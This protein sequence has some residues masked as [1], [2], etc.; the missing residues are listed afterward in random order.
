MAAAPDET[1]PPPCACAP[2][3]AWA[4]GDGPREGVDDAETMALVQELAQYGVPEARGSRAGAGSPEAS[5]RP[6]R[7]PR[8]AAP[9]LRSAR[10]LL[11]RLSSCPLAPAPPLRLPP[12]AKTGPP[13]TP[14]RPQVLS[15]PDGVVSGRRA[16]LGAVAAA[17]EE[18][19][20]TAAAA[21]AASWLRRLRASS[22]SGSGSGSGGEGAGGGGGRRAAGS[23][24]TVGERGVVPEGQALPEDEELEALVAAQLEAQGKR[25]G[26]GGAPGGAALAEVL[27][28]EAV[29]WGELDAVAAL[30]LRVAGKRSSLPY[31]LLQLRPPPPPRAGGLRG[32]R[33]G[34]STAAIGGAAA[35]GGSSSGD[36]VSSSFGGGGGQ[37]SGGSGGDGYAYSASDGLDV[38]ADPLLPP[39]RRCARLS[40]AVASILDLHQGEGRQAMLEHASVA[41]RLRAAAVHLIRRRR[42]LVAISSVA[43][44]F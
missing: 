36:G 15:L 26:R 24:N 31:G 8:R 7:V 13:V 1:S 37:L 29:V 30:M 35:A 18:A 25:R 27:A 40:W 16:D 19:A 33:G 2:P 17:A 12:T 39:L 28:L 32:G 38:F 21:S 11:A 5:R 22:G 43:D 42:R 44:I 9:G 10:G 6:G 14:A 34:D 20:C 41:G 23:L 4:H 3:Q